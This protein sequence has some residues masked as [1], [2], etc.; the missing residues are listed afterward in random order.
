MHRWGSLSVGLPSLLF[1][2]SPSLHLPLFLLPLTFPCLFSYFPSPSLPPSFFLAPPPSLLPSFY[3]RSPFF[4]LLSSPSLTHL[5][6][7]FPLPSLFPPL[8]LFVS[9]LC[10]CLWTRGREREKE[11]KIGEI[12]GRGEETKVGGIGEKE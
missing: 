7:I 6:S 12:G 3:R 1:F 2:F 8:P 4:F 10:S 11:A 9:P 5:P